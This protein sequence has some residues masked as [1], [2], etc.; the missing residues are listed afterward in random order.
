MIQIDTDYLLNT[1]KEMI[2]IN[3]VIP[4]EE[5]LA[6]YIAEKIRQ[7]GLEPEWHEVAPGRPNVYASADLGGSNHFLT[8]TGHMDTVDVAQNWPTDPFEPVAK[9][10]KLYGLGSMDMKG[11]LACA[12][13]AFKAL[14]EAKEW[15]GR[16]GRIG[17]AAT[18]DEEGYGTGARAL[19]QTEYGQSDAL[20]LGEPFYGVGAGWS[21][22]NGIT[23]KVLYKLTVTGRTAHAFHP[24]RGV[25]AVEDAGK[26][27]AALAQLQLGQHPLFGRGNYST[28]KFEGGY[29]EYAVVVPEQCEV[30]I[31]RLTVPGESVATAVA[32]MQAP[33]DSLNL[34]SHVTIET[35]PPFYEP[36]LLAETTPIFRAFKPAYEETVGQPPQFTTQKGITDSNIYVAE[37]NIPTIV[38]GPRGSGA[39]EAGEYVETATLEPVTRVYVETA[40]RFFQQEMTHE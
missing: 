34:A 29:K 11:G 38:F 25:N 16:L 35:P 22:P 10:G 24:E 23:G 36:Y 17:F 20:L 1:L 30:I 2:R 15:H 18:V 27:V 33:V 14:V 9:E 19:L 26:I 12:L 31:T 8:L 4:H 39:H 37:G 21:L 13:T 6:V 7:L 5:K 32:D 40:V 3:S 28:L